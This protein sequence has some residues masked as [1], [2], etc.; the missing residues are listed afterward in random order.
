MSNLPKTQ[1]QCDLSH[2]TLKIKGKG[3][4]S[5]I[6][7]LDERAYLARER[8]ASAS[9]IRTSATAAPQRA[10]DLSQVFYSSLFA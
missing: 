10:D 6:V 4:V 8:S 2:V 7:K 5:R 1:K 9:P 3:R